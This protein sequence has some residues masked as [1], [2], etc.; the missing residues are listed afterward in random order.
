MPDPFNLSRRPKMADSESIKRACSA[1]EDA[2]ARAA[3][4]A[5]CFQ[6][7][8]TDMDE[9]IHEPPWISMHRRTI[10]ELALLASNLIEAINR[11]GL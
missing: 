1:L 6:A 11:S 2:L 5:E 4:L 8:R 7:T 10:D 9:S 3:N